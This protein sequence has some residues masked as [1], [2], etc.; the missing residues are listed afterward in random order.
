MKETTMLPQKPWLF[1]VARNRALDELRRKYPITFSQLEIAQ[2][3]DNVSPIE[4]MPDT[5]LLPEEIAELQQVLRKAIDE[6]PL[7]FRQ[8]VLLRYTAHI[9]FKEIGTI[10]QMPEATAKT[11]FRRARPL[12]R[13]ALSSYQRT[14]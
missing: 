14:V 8:V 10:L 11:Y 1:Q 3:E 9:P 2:E 5:G 13:Q 6:L 4:I 7:K 12:L